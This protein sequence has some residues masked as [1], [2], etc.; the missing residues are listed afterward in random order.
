MGLAV[1]PLFILDNNVLVSNRPRLDSHL[2]SSIGAHSHDSCVTEQW[3]MQQELQL[4][5]LLQVF[6][7][8]SLSILSCRLGVSV[9]TRVLATLFRLSRLSTKGGQSTSSKTRL[10]ACR[11]SARMTFFDFVQIS[12]PA[13]FRRLP[14]PT[15]VSTRTQTLCDMDGVKKWPIFFSHLTICCHFFSFFSFCLFFSFIF[16]FFIFLNRSCH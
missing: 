15:P 10:W 1:F 3:H 16:L 14:A 13:A 6:F 9:Q 2:T 8:L 12:P 5:S 7:D 4:S 11:H